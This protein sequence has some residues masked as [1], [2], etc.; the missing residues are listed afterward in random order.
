MRGYNRV[1]M[2]C[3][4]LGFYEWRPPGTDT[5]HSP[6]KGL[7]GPPPS[8]LSS[9]PFVTHT[10]SNPRNRLRFVTTTKRN[11]HSLQRHTLLHLESA[12]LRQSQRLVRT[13]LSQH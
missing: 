8:P 13:T 2:A 7:A 1:R 6:V 12:G 11:A 5:C 9:L 10:A 4:L 3:E